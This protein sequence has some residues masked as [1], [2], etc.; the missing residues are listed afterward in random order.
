M[1]CEFKKDRHQKTGWELGNG[2]NVLCF[3]SSLPLLP[4]ATTV[5]FGSYLPVISLFLTNIVSSV[6]ACLII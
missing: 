5:V 4:P 2:T 6:R 3:L 1:L